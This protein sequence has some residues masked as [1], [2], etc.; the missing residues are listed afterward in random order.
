ML[1]Y[2]LTPLQRD[3]RPLPLHHRAHPLDHRR[4]RPSRR[5]EEEGGGW[6]L[7][8]RD[9]DY[10]DYNRGGVDSSSDSGGDTRCP[11]PNRS[12]RVERDRARRGHGRIVRLGGDTRLRPRGDDGRAVGPVWEG[13]GWRDVATTVGI[14]RQG[15][16]VV[17]ELG[18]VE[19]VVHG[20]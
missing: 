15:D 14:A 10:D 11:W 1:Q 4:R 16:D 2:Y 9:D 5:R 8:R 12:T 6:L 18:D 3:P 19:R 13:Y 20:M 17:R 7:W